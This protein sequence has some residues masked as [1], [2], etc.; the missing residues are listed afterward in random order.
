MS[1]FH[2]MGKKRSYFEGWYLKQTGQDGTIAFI[3]AFHADRKGRK[4]ASLQIVTEES[5]MNKNFSIDLF[6]ASQNRFLVQID[7]CR[8]SKSGCKL[9]VKS[10][11]I[12]ATGILNYE[13]VRK[14]KYNIMGPFSL[15]P[16]LE[17]RH[18]VISMHHAVSGQIEINGKRYHF[19]DGL[20][21]IEGDRGRS[22]PGNYC[23]TQCYWKEGSI[24]LSVADIPFM[25]QSF[26]GCVGFLY[27]N[28]KE[29]RLATYLG[30]KVKKV[31]KEEIVVEQGGLSLEVRLIRENPHPLKAPRQ[32][33]MDRQIHESPACTVFYR[34]CQGGT[35]IFSHYSENAGFEWDMG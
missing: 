20:G 18:S 21:Y 12:T 6:H 26:L 28:G 32:G 3:P 9:E 35:E 29:H 23:W 15:V 5:S 11:E 24:M 30:V 2:G 7:Q 14:P 4:W 1:Y 16:F 13:Q 33:S 10:P 31:S 19:R 27:L 17:C 8:F 34:V 25:G 22:F